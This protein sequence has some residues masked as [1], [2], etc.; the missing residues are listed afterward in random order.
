MISI[1]VLFEHADDPRRT[2]VCDE[3]SY[4][5]DLDLDQVVGTISV[6]RKQ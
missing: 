2:I 1:S 3:P 5:Q 6:S 4:F